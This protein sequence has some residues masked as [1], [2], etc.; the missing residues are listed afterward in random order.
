MAS[1]LVGSTVGRHCRSE[2]QQECLPARSPPRGPPPT[3]T[4]AAGPEQLQPLQVIGGE[5]DPSEMV[6]DGPRAPSVSCHGWV[7]MVVSPWSPRSADVT[8]IRCQ[9]RA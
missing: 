5:L 1:P 3:S 7:L 2:P 6:R 9:D 8:T 4:P